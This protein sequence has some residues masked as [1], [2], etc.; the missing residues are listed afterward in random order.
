MEHLKKMPS[1]RK[2]QQRNLSLQGWQTHMPM[3]A[4]HGAW[5]TRPMK[6]RTYPNFKPGSLPPA[7][8]LVGRRCGGSPLSAGP[9]ARPQRPL[10][11]LPPPHH[12]VPLQPKVVRQTAGR[13]RWSWQGICPVLAAENG[14]AAL[15]AV[16]GQR[17]HPG[18]PTLRAELQRVP[19]APPRQSLEQA[20]PMSTGSGDVHGLCASCST[21]HRRLQ[22][23]RA[24][25]ASEISQAVR[26]RFGVYKACV[27]CTA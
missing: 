6:R 19:A 27:S 5:Q 7:R 9:T 24:D 8:P 22:H 20:Q 1:G 21:I 23:L 11:A 13:K 3:W 25:R 4:L 14:E 16:A 15:A 12:R 18:A 17:R 26:E 2:Q 10:A